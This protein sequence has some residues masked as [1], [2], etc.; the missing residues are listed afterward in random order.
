MYLK[1]GDKPLI[2][3]ITNIEYK[4]DYRINFLESESKVTIKSFI[5]YD[6]C[7]QEKR[8][9]FFKKLYF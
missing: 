6:Y 7:E 4:D 3:F 9:L 2:I 5:D 8:S 1:K